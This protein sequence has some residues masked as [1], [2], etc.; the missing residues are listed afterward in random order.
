MKIPI[1]RESQLITSNY[2]SYT[3]FK[4]LTKLYKDYSKERFSLIVNDTILPIRQSIKIQEDPI[5]KLTI[6]EKIKT[7]E[8]VLPEKGL[9]EKAATIKRFR[10]PPLGRELKKQQTGIAK[11]RYKFFKDQINV[12]N[13]KRTFTY[14]LKEKTCIS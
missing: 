4:D 6:S 7:G 5:I 2:L 10:H 11:D 1:K 8:H 9:L 3:D 13:N 14:V 12:D